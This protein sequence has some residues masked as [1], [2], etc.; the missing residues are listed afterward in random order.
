[1]SRNTIIVLMYKPTGPKW[2][3]LENILKESILAWSI[4]ILAYRD[5]G[6]PWDPCVKYEGV[7][8]EIRV[9]DLPSTG[10]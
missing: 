2:E 3:D 1:M 8:P 5:W 6:T 4:L 10:T 7:T 9:E